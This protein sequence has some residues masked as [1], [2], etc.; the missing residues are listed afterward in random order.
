[1]QRQCKPYPVLI[2]QKD[3]IREFLEDLVSKGVLSK[4]KLVI[5]LS[6]IFYQEKKDSG[7]RLLTDLRE[8]NKVLECD[9]WPLE[10]IDEVLHSIGKFKFIMILN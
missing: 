9:E 8:L 10:N 7:I 5:W 2:M 3:L 1:M 4:C 6:S